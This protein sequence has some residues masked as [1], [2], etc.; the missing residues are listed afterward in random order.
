MANARTVA[1][2]QQNIQS[3]IASLAD[4]IVV[5]FD[6]NK[7][8][9]QRNSLVAEGKTAL[10]LASGIKSST[11]AAMTASEAEEQTDLVI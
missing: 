10:E 4:I 1:S 11:W 7:S 9:D 3:S 8:N 5:R 6:K 2:Q